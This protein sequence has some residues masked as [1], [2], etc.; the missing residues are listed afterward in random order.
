M[1]LKLEK[2][3]ER[4]GGRIVVNSAF[5]RV[6]YLY[7]IKSAQD[8]RM[9]E[10]AYEHIQCRQAMSLRQ[11]SE[12]GMRAFQGSFPRIKDRFTYEERGER[13]LMLWC[14]VLLFNLRTRLVGLNQ[15]LST[16]MPELGAEANYFLNHKIGIQTG[17]T[18]IHDYFFSFK[19]G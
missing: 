13:K 19:N 7:L 2:E 16:F 14:T 9:A 18:D 3:F 10:G 17:S 5:S 15:I 6:K 12:W 4:N 8:E 1:Y 11:A